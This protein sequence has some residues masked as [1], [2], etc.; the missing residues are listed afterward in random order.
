MNHKLARARSYASDARPPK[1]TSVLLRCMAAIIGS[2]ASVVPL[3]ARH[4]RSEGLRAS[5]YEQGTVCARCLCVTYR[6]H[7]WSLFKRLVTEIRN[8]RLSNGAAAL[9]FY[10]TLA[11]F[12]AAIFVLSVLPYL[13]I[14]HLQEPIFDL[15]Y[16]LLPG[17]AAKLFT[18]TVT[19]VVSQRSSTLVSFG[20]LFT[21]WSASSGTQAMID[22][23]NVVYGV[24][25]ARPFWKARL[26]AVLLVFTFMVLIVLTFGL[27]IFGGVIQDWLASQLGWSHTL[28]WFFAIFRWIVLVFALLS[29]FALI[30]RIAPNVEHRRFRLFHGGTVLAAAG[31]LATSFGFKVYVGNFANYDATYGSLGAAIV[32]LLWLLIAGWML[33][34]GGELNELLD[35][36]GEAGTVAAKRLDEGTTFSR[37][38]RLR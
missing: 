12:P 27:V 32:L 25:E 17:D 10:S 36:K 4:G 15:L 38:Q 33:L 20:L 37:D 8:D 6:E 14:P 3:S 16:Q 23:L 2:P 1:R 21:V 19:T 31:F 24:R 34:V 29:C 5:R 35:G 7:T 11:L 28:R 26:I 18:E 30:Y 9:A 22:Q 13:P